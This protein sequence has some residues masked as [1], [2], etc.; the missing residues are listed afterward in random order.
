ML[1]HVDYAGFEL[2]EKIFSSKNSNGENFRDEVRNTGHVW[3]SGGK[4]YD[5]GE[6]LSWLS[7]DK[8]GT[9]AIGKFTGPVLYHHLKPV[10]R[11]RFE[12]GSIVKRE[13]LLPHPKVVHE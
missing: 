7:L 12:W 9:Q 3:F 8:V 5:Q 10:R 13:C 2:R 1:G 6:Q 4:H 11:S